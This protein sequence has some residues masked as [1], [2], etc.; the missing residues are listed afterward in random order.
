MCINC[1]IWI[2][3]SM[4]FKCLFITFLICIHDCCFGLYIIKV[5]RSL[6]SFVPNPRNLRPWMRYKLLSYL[7]RQVDRHAYALTNW[8]H[9]ILIDYIFPVWDHLADLEQQLYHSPWSLCCKLVLDIEE[10]ARS[11]DPLVILSIVGTSGSTFRW[12]ITAPT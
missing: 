7:S 11:S 12:L 9:W 4:H 2:L 10:T 5:T 6:A 3:L 1:L 8:T